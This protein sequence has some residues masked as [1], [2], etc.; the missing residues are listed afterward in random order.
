MWWITNS[1]LVGHSF[2]SHWRW[3]RHWPSRCNHISDVGWCPINNRHSIFDDRWCI[4]NNRCNIY[5]SGR[6]IFDDGCNIFDSGY[7]TFNDG[8]NI[9]D[10]GC[11]TFDDGCNIFDSRRSIFDD[12]C[13]LFGDRWIFINSPITKSFNHCIIDNIFRHIC[14]DIFDHTRRS[15]GGEWTPNG[16]EERRG[17]P[18]HRKHGHHR[19]VRRGGRTAAQVRS[20]HQLPTRRVAR[21]LSGQFRCRFSIEEWTLCLQEQGTPFKRKNC[22]NE[23]CID[24]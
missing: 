19:W 24:W 13:D 23:S 7:N 6:N 12:R 5:D 20:Q 1:F 11:N 21:Y 10:S 16:W 4:F 2:Q 9:I 3:S 18:S 14:D 17:D 8:C 22:I 15:T